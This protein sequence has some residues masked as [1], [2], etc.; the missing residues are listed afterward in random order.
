[1]HPFVLPAIISLQF[2]LLFTNILLLGIVFFIFET[3]QK[4]NYF[5]KLYN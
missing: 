3:I 1:M 4:F 5:I 2:Q